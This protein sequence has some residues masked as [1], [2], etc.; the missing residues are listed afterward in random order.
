M[1]FGY[2]SFGPEVLGD[3]NVMQVRVPLDLAPSILSVYR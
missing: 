2:D 1:Q 3:K